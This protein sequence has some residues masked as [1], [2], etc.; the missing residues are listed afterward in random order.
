MIENPNNSNSQVFGADPLKHYASKFFCGCLVFSGCFLTASVLAG[1]YL[2]FTPVYTKS[3]VSDI[4]AEIKGISQT[5][6]DI[7][8]SLQKR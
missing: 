3:T 7:R 8:Q 4:D 2:V 6:L 1:L 5:L